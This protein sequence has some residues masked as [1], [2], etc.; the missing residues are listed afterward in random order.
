MLWWEN[1]VILVRKICQNVKICQGKKDASTQGKKQYGLALPLNPL[2]ATWVRGEGRHD[3]P[4]S[5]GGVG[6]G[7]SLPP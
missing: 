3:V 7:A 6:G 2:L 5:R 1:N 4:D